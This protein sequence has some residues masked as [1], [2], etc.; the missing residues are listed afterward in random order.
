MVAPG[1][2]AGLDGDEAVAALVVGHHA[3]LAREVGIERRVVLVAR[4]DV[5]AAG[6][7][8]PDLDQGTRHRAPVLVDDAAGDD[9]AFAQAARPCA[10][11]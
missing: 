11:A 10:G 5:A 2:G 7:G 8:L 3:A 6:V 1:I 9:D 4:M